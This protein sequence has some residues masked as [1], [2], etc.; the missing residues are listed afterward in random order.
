MAEAIKTVGDLAGICGHDGTSWEKILIDSTKRLVVAIAAFSASLEVTQDTPGDL[1]AGIHGYVGGAWQKLPM[2]WGYSDTISELLEDDNA[3]AGLNT[4]DTTAVPSGEIHVIHTL[5]GVNTNN[6]PTFILMSLVRGG[7]TYFL[8]R[9]AGP[10]AGTS[11]ELAGTIV[12][13]GGDL[14]RC[15]IQGCVLNDNIRF[16]ITGYKVDIDL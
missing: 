5:Y 10:G 6:N 2:L 9:V 8:K 11:V 4:L 3:T 13:E 14:L 15:S 16:A 12:M 7:E 1:L